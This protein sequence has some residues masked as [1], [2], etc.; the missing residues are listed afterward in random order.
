MQGVLPKIIFKI[1]EQAMGFW[2]KFTAINQKFMHIFFFILLTSKRLLYL[3]MNEYTLLKK[4]LDSLCLAGVFILKLTLHKTLFI[5]EIYKLY[6]KLRNF[7][8]TFLFVN[9]C[10]YSTFLSITLFTPVNLSG[11]F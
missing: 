3:Y 10:I 8:K 5:L 4:Y 1:P 7:I 11:D 6:H 9:Y 2:G